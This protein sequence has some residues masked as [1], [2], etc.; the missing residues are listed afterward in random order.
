MLR[1]FVFV[2]GPLLAA[3]VISILLH[4]CVDRQRARWLK[5]QKLKNKA[6][7]LA[8][9]K[10]GKTPITAVEKED[11]GVGQESEAAGVG[12]SGTRPKIDL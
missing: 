11:L 3:L 10:N 1:V 7:G 8:D 12:T 9:K 4:W 5:A 6:P 2:M